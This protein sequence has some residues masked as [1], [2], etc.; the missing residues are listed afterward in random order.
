MIT[1]LLATL[2]RLPTSIV[3]YD[4]ETSGLS[5]EYDQIFQIA[6][7]RSDHSFSEPSSKKSILELRAR[8]Q[9]WIVPSPAAM[10]VTRMDPITLSSGLFHHEMIAAA[11]DYLRARPAIYLTYNGLKFDERFLRNALFRSLCRPYLT[12]SKGSTRADLMVMAQAISVLDP[13]AVIVPKTESGRP[14]F[15]LGALCRVNNI[16]FP[17]EIAHDALADVRATLALARH[18]KNSSPRLFDQTLALSDKEHA[19]SVL[20][21]GNALYR[22][23]VFGGRPSV[24]AYA[25]I[26]HTEDDSN[27]RLCVDLSDDPSNY[28]ALGVD[29]LSK[30]MAKRP[31]PLATLRS[32]AHEMVFPI[33]SDISSQ[34]HSHIRCKAKGQI[35]P[36]IELLQERADKIARNAAFVDRLHTVIAEQQAALTPRPHVD[37]QLYSGGFAPDSDFHHARSILAD[38]HVNIHPSSLEPLRDPRLREFA[39]RILYEAAAGGLDE[40]THRRL[41]TWKCERLLGPADAPWRTIAAAREELGKLRQAVKETD[42]SRLLEID[43]W[44]SALEADARRTLKTYF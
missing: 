19:A 16:D 6:A 42:Q 35:T 22:L 4:I 7:L 23:A 36:P 8:R 28:L 43:E 41:E 12:Q 3:V 34:L 29:N 15:R 14:T 44:L 26:D 31:S 37:S 20:R 32:N 21:P 5:P 25:V 18:L 10:L 11:E 40:P 27:G 38:A 1:S 33:R 17:D 24:R 2:V 9:P 13:Q 30:W 39:S